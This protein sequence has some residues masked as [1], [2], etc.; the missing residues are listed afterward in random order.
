MIA[1]SMNPEEGPQAT[2]GSGS[3]SAA[4]TGAG[5]ARGSHGNRGRRDLQCD[6]GERTE[7]RE[8]SRNG[9]RRRRFDTRVATIDLAIPKLRPAP[10]AS[11]GCWSGRSAPRRRSSRIGGCNPLAGKE[12]GGWIP[13]CPILVK[14]SP[15]EGSLHQPAAE[16]SRSWG[17]NA[18]RI[19][20]PRSDQA[21]PTRRNSPASSS[22]RRLGIPGSPS[23]ETRGGSRSPSAR[24]RRRQAD[25]FGIRG[26]ER[27]GLPSSLTL[28]GRWAR[29]PKYALGLR[30]ISTSIRVI[31]PRSTTVAS[32]VRGVGSGFLPSAD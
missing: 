24:G 13:E 19:H 5:D 11:T 17:R 2:G 29:L 6:Y 10:T 23:P 4:C 12:L 15:L 22:G 1:S 31:R 8:T 14:W 3:R 16:G 26:S 27:S 9:Y 20:C 7:E 32:T 18:A 25:R 21:S 28:S 30:R